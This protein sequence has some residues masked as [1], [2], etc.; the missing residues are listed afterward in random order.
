MHGVSLEVNKERTR[1]S[2]SEELKDREGEK[3]MRV[4]VLVHQCIASIHGGKRSRTGGR[5]GVVTVARRTA[6]SVPVSCCMML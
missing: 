4:I 6:L 3:K 5:T 2:W 1:P